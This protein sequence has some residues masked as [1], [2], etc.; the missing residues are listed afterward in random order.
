M[1]GEFEEARAEE[2]K[3]REKRGR[4]QGKLG[5]SCPTLERSWAFFF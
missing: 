1:P 2:L 3:G 5:P 4:S